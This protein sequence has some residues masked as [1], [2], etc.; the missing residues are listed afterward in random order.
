MAGAAPV[1]GP[2]YHSNADRGVWVNL[3]LRRSHRFSL[4]MGKPIYALDMIAHFDRQE[5]ASVRIHNLGGMRL[6]QRLEIAERGRG[7][8]GLAFRQTFMA[9]NLTITVN[10]LMAGKRVEFPDILEILALEDQIKEASH[11]FSRVLEAAA[12]FDG[13]E[14]WDFQGHAE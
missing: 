11:T 6:Y 1:G 2:A 4:L 14:V 9:T 10:D 12:H 3:L 13:E 8:L 7:L 5:Q